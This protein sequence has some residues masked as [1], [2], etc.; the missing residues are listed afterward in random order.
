MAAPTYGINPTNTHIY[1]H[2]ETY[3]ADSGQLSVAGNG[4][5]VPANNVISITLEGDDT[6]HTLN[7]TGTSMFLPLR[8]V[9]VVPQES[10]SVTVFW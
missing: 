7:I 8:V 4:I 2:C 6:T 3:T 1:S 9:Q 10:S 5:F